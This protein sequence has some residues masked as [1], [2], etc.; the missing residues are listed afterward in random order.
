M[1]SDAKLQKACQEIVERA[2][3]GDQNA[4]AILVQTRENAKKGNPLAAKSH[5]MML[6]FAKHTEGDRLDLPPK[7]SGNGRVSTALASLRD[8]MRSVRHPIKYLQS[9]RTNVPQ[10]GF[11]LRDS[12]NAAQAVSQGP[13]IIDATIEGAAQTFKSDNAKEVFRS[14]VNASGNIKELMSLPIADEESKQARQAGYVMGLARRFQ[15]VR[16]G[17][18]IAIYSKLAAWELGE[19]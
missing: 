15:T 12:A 2:K 18:P 8:T 7:M 11:S 4:E 13:T 1:S 16:Q 10:V 19:I 9:I 17:G 6:A 14:A 3:L 5:A